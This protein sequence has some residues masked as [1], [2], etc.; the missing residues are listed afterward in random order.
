M[1]GE[2]ICKKAFDEFVA[3]CKVHDPE[4][5]WSVLESVGRYHDWCER[6]DRIVA[7]VDEAYSSHHDGAR[8]K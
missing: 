6:A 7:W 4:G 5:N 1:T 8:Q 3:W 2:D